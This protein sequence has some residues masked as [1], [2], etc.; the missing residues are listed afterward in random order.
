MY[1]DGIVNTSSSGSGSASASENMIKKIK[2]RM[3]LE[4]DVG[5]FC[6]G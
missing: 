3:Y 4:D 2:R 5:D 6:E 1:D